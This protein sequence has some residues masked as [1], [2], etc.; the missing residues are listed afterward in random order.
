[1]AKKIDLATVLGSEYERLLRDQAEGGNADVMFFKEKS[2]G[3]CYALKG[4][5]VLNART[6]KRFE[7]EVRFVEEHQLT[8]NGILP[9]IKSEVSQYWYLMPMAEPVAEHLNGAKTV[10]EYVECIV[11]LAGVLEQIHNLN[12]AHR[13]IKPENIYW[14]HGHYCLGDFGLVY[15]P[16]NPNNVTIDEHQVG[17]KATMAPEMRRHPYDA[18]GKKADVYSLAKTLWILLTKQTFGFDGE[19]NFM[20][21]SIALRSFRFWKD[22]VSLARIERLLAKS[23][24]NAPEDRPS[25]SQFKHQLEVWLRT[26]GNEDA[27]QRDEWLFMEESLFQHNHPQS[28]IWTELRDIEYVL[29]VV[30]NSYAYNHLLYSQQGGLDLTDVSL[31]SEN[32]F[33]ELRA[34]GLTHILKP[35]CLHYETF[36]NSAWNYFLLEIQKVEPILKENEDGV[37]VLVE[38]IPGHYVNAD[39]FVYGVYNYDSG[40]P[41]PKTARQV[42]RFCEG[43]MMIVMKMGTYNAIA[44]TY[45]GRHGNMTP[46]QLR[47]YVLR[48]MIC[49]KVGL[50]LEK[51]VNYLLPGG[52]QTNV[53]RNDVTNKDSRPFLPADYI[54]NNYSTWNFEGCRLFEETEEM[55]K[56]CYKFRLKYNTVFSLYE[57][58]YQCDIILLSEMGFFEKNC[59]H[60]YAVY[61]RENALAVRDK[62]NE[63]LKELCS[64][65]Q[66]SFWEGDITIVP[67]RIGNPSHLFTY[68]EVYECMHQA[69]DRKGTRLVV[70]E[71]G[72]VHVLEGHHRDYDLYPVYG[73][74]FNPRNN[75]VGKYSDFPLRRDAYM[76]LLCGWERYLKSGKPQK[77]G[78][79]DYQRTEQDVLNSIRILTEN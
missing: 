12:F 31:A 56:I 25:I 10:K 72:L 70:D 42:E 67:S 34:N 71:N 36:E 74:Y 6:K 2:T 53:V 79:W 7:D 39:D 14:Y 58:I 32:G 16:N 55:N 23:T 63:R 69:D 15:I 77:Y 35:K 38:D 45:D 5:R 64:D 68:E 28:T 3:D 26:M 27:M 8:I 24:K 19:Y 17:A 30:A 41:L 18:D 33:L 9:I 43:T 22:D 13:D 76:D 21:K 1:M 62:L 57:D 61:S 78:V 52:I 46:L 73:T 20:D 40:E 29:R 75:Y 59:A 11:E 60:P 51:M 44:A 54:R 65:Y 47:D 49:E 37:E 66:S 48:L 4:L 50:P